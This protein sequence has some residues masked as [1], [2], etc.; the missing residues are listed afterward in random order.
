[1]ARARE[2]GV[3]AVLAL[4]V[5]CAAVR[6]ALVLYAPRAEAFDATSR[7]TAALFADYVAVALAAQARIDAMTSALSQRDVI[8]QAKGILMAREGLD[9]EGAFAHLAH[10]SQQRNV[11]LVQVARELV[12][13]ALRG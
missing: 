5:S 7:A 2:A 9:A 6:G 8:G 13:D 1:V 4:D 10:A 3:G 12:G 11:K